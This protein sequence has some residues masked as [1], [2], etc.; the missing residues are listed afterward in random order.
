[1]DIRIAGRY[2]LGRKLGAGSFGEIYL[3]MLRVLGT[4]EGCQRGISYAQGLGKSACCIHI[5]CMQYHTLLGSRIEILRPIYYELLVIYTMFC[6]GQ[7]AVRRPRR[8]AVW[9]VDWM[10]LK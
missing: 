10:G 4:P 2:R 3:G 1:M 9:L 8:F 7:L 6:L 5:E